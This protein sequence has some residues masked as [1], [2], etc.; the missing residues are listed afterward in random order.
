MGVNTKN[1]RKGAVA[2]PANEPIPMDPDEAVGGLDPATA[3]LLDQVNRE[4]EAEITA[5]ASLIELRRAVVAEH[6]PDAPPARKAADD[7]YR[8]DYPDDAEADDM[9][10]QDS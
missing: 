2:Q 5:R 3:A 7:R 9:G 8:D 4:K 6:G 1:P 10:E